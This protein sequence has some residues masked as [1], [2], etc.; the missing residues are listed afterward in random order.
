MEAQQP[1][2]PL[3]GWLTGC[4]REANAGQVIDEIWLPP[5]GDAL[6]G[7]AR[8][9]RSDTLRS[10]EQLVIRRGSNGLVLE[11]TPSGQPPAAFLAAEVNDTVIAF[12]NLTH[13]FPQV[14]R[15]QRLG[16]DS[17]LAVVSGTIGE[18]QRAIEF[19]YARVACPGS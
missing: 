15:Y 3:P 14:I 11:A 18:R 19:D 8:T 13:D 9:V 17:L 4:W 12:E 7:M 5:A 16:R 2:A 6:V 1:Q 10:W